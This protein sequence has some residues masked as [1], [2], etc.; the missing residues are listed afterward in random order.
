[1]KFQPFEIK[2]K[3]FDL[4]LGRERPKIGRWG[5][6]GFDGGERL[7]GSQAELKALVKRLQKTTANGNVAT[8]VN[9]NVAKAPVALAA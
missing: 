6:F 5:R 4:D 1:M 9:G 7:L 2:R 3:K 8:A